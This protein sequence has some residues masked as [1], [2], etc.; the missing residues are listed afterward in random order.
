MFT[1]IINFVD[2]S[3]AKCTMNVYPS[4]ATLPKDIWDRL[5]SIEELEHIS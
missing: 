4:E 5:A 1:F 2:G 3:R